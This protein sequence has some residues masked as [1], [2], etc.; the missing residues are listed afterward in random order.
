MK[1]VY[2]KIIFVFFIANL[3]VITPA[4]AGEWNFPLGFTFISGFNDITDLHEDNLNSS[5]YTTDSV[6]G[7][8]IGLAFRPYYLTDFGLGFGVDIG[9]A[10][11]IFGD[12]DFFNL[13]VNVNMRYAFASTTAF[14]PYIR[15]GLSYN[16][17]SG[18]YVEDK[19]AGLIGAVGI[20]FLRNKRVHF[21]F[22]FAYDTSEIEFEDLSSADGTDELRPCGFTASIFAVF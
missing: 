2:M 17:A 6:D 3:V 5:G 20:E 13:P 9:P 22:E 11:M 19:S 10:M 12:V 16:L 14:S 18:D 4:T 1:T 21:G 7:L 15:A 8:P